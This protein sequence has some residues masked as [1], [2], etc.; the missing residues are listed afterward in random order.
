MV[1][2]LAEALV[3]ALAPVLLD[4]SSAFFTEEDIK[5]AFA[6]KG[7]PAGSGRVW[8]G[9]IC[10][11]SSHAASSDASSSGVVANSARQRSTI[12]GGS[13]TSVNGLIRTGPLSR[14]CVVIASRRNPGEQFR[15]LKPG[16]VLEQVE[17]RLIELR[18]PKAGGVTVP[19]RPGAA[20]HAADVMG[21]VEDLVA[22]DLDRK[23]LARAT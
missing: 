14:S 15:K 13:F 4:G 6:T 16:G 18:P 3:K 7:R 8:S 17:R 11:G 19:Q 9:S 12:S 10:H 1:E 23:A 20:D 2:A 21:L 5:A 22:G